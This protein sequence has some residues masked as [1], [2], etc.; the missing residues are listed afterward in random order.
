MDQPTRSAGVFCHVTSLPGGHGAGDLGASAMQFVDWLARAGQGIWQV[1]PLGPPGFGES[2]YQ[3]LSAFA[4]NTLLI[5]LEWLCRQGWLP[6]SELELAPRVPEATVNFE[7]VRAFRWHCLCLAFDAFHG[8]RAAAARQAF[9]AFRHDE[10][11]WLDDF[12]LFAALKH[13]NGGRPWTQWSGAVANPAAARR[14]LTAA[15]ALAVE[16]E[17]FFQFCFCTQWRELQSYARAK[18]VRLMGDL[19]IFVAHDS[20]DVWANRRLFHLDS[21]GNPSVVAGVPPDYFSK[22]GQLW[23]NPIY[24]WDVLR[25]EDYAWWISRLRYSLTQFDLVRLDH[26]RGFQAYWEV[27]AGAATAAQGRWV[28]GPGAH[29]FERARSTL[30]KLPLVAEDLGH[31]TPEVEAL[32]CQCGFPGMRVLQFAFGADPS[33][34]N[35]RPHY[36]TRH[37]VVY[38]G[39][40]DNDTIVGWFHASEGAGTTRGA[41]ELARERAFALKYLGCDGFAIHWQMIRLA[42]ASVADTAI[43]PLQDLLGLGSEARMNL[44][45]TMAAGNWRWRCASHALTPRLA[46]QLRE[47]CEVYDRVCAPAAPAPASAG[48]DPG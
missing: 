38:T 31:I 29:F 27:P 24:R 43:V 9:D 47:L 28:P 19:P 35:N 21:R 11:W 36:F 22:T 12:A 5:S 40:H 15:Q 32:R 3:S 34:R 16:R 10:A 37:C 25:Q 7:A 30:G 46:D 41:A 45:G 2:P 23:G 18:G 26:F 4:G 20:A 14:Q 17:A 39:T 48:P 1:L 44:P 13:L 6:R 42:L 33:E 8:A